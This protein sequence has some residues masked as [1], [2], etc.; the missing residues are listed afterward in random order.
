MLIQCSSHSITN[1]STSRFALLI[2]QHGKFLHSFIEKKI[3]VRSILTICTKRLFW[4]PINCLILLQTINTHAYGCVRSLN[5]YSHTT[6]KCKSVPSV[7]AQLKNL[8]IT[9]ESQHWSN[10]DKTA[11]TDSK[12]YNRLH[13]K[14]IIFAQGNVF[15][16]TLK[17]YDVWQ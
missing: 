2:R 14:L 7:I 5:K 11:A 1:R 9:T 15:I 4:K 10:V 13:D 17:Y 8:V 6:Q 12:I 16:D 3:G